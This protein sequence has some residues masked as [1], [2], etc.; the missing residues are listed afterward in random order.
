MKITLT[1]IQANIF[2]LYRKGMTQK[3]IATKLG[4]HQS[5][6]SK[7]LER[8][9]D[10]IGCRDLKIYCNRPGYEVIDLDY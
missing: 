9:K 10:K 3:E 2:K 5:N 4:C 6:I 1:S 8:I 7:H